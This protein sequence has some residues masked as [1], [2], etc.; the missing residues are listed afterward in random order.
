MPSRRKIIKRK[1]AVV[2]IG[3]LSFAFVGEEQPDLSVGSC[4]FAAC[5]H[6]DDYQGGEDHVGG[7]I[8]PAA[9]EV[10]STRAARDTEVAETVLGSLKKLQV[11]ELEQTNSSR[12]EDLTTYRLRYLWWADKK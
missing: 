7:L 3:K 6:W 2:R 12:C 9:W 11:I 5:N 1:E 8:L 10:S 4:F